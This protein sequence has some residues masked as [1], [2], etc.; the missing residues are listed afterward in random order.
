MNVLGLALSPDGRSCRRA[1][2]GPSGSGIRKTGQ[3][4]LCLTDRKARVNSVAFSPNGSILAA[5]DHS[6]P[7]TLWRTRPSR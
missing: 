5:A 7:V 3:E 1:R 4:L 6:G 2:T